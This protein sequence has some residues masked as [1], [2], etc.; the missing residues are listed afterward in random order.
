[1]SKNTLTLN[2]IG[3]SLDPRLGKSGAN[4]VGNESLRY[5]DNISGKYNINRTGVIMTMCLLG[6][7]LI[8]T[9]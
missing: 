1:M 5:T 4:N 6:Y 3:I 2:Y 7:N 9:Y 8:Y